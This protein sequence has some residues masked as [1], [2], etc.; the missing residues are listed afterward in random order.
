ME[1]R[2]LNEIVD[3]DQKPKSNSSKRN[4]GKDEFT[5]I[6]DKIILEKGLK[7]KEFDKQA[8]LKARKKIYDEFVAENID[9]LFLKEK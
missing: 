3:K 5:K 1:N 4:R 2:D 9:L 6:T 7:P 8:I